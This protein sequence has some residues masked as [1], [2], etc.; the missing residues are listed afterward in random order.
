[1]CSCQAVVASTSCR[2]MQ[3]A[4][5]VRSTRVDR[6]SAAGQERRERR[7]LCMWSETMARVPD[8]RSTS[9]LRTRENMPDVREPVNPSV[10]RSRRAVWKRRNG[11]RVTPILAGTHP[12]VAACIDDG[13]PLTKPIDEGLGCM[14]E[15]VRQCGFHTVSVR[16]R[17]GAIRVP[18]TTVLKFTRFAQ[19]SVGKTTKPRN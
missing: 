13:A 11:S 9:M 10:T 1:M 8:E 12:A 5:G 7:T 14:D 3:T 16:G 4:A 6:F 17:G 2:T 19:M 18:G 15:R